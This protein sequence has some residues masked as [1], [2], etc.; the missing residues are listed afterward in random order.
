MTSRLSLSVSVQSAGERADVS[1]GQFAARLM[2]LLSSAL[3]ALP[4]HDVSAVWAEVRAE[5]L[6]V[7]ANHEE[8]AVRAAVLKVGAER[9]AAGVRQ[10]G[11][12]KR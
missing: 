2:V 8:P 1:C 12:G 3:S 9:P 4:E 6:C 5:H 7:L 10:L 11:Q